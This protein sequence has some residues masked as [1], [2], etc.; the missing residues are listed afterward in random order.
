MVYIDEAHDYFAEGAGINL[1]L[2]TA[3]KF[4]VGLVVSHQNLG[5]FPR[6]LAATVMASTSI[7]FAG[8]VSFDDARAL[9]REMHC[10]VEFLQN[11]RKRGG[12]T[13]FSLSMRNVTDIAR[14]V[15]I[16][17]GTLEGKA[18]MSPA[19]YEELLANNRRRY[20]A[21]VDPTVLTGSV[22]LSHGLPGFSPDPFQGV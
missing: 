1:L 9:S 10:E 6:S 13:R 19:E 16:P 17:F 11:M 3:R 8:G 18:Q 2:N 20:C 15:V 22:A 21:P 4:Q 5:Q 7:K 12:E 14:E